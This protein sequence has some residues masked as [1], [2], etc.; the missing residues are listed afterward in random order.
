MGRNALPE[1]ISSLSKSEK[2]HVLLFLKR[3][4]SDSIL[5]DLYKAYSDG[6]KKVASLKEEI[7][8]FHFHNN[9]LY[10][11]ILLALRNVHQ[12]KNVEGR[13]RALITDGEIL[14]HRSLYEQA[15]TK[16]GAAKALSK[17]HEKF[18]LELECIELDRKIRHRMETLNSPK[19]LL[20][21]EW[22]RE[23]ELIESIKIRCGYRYFAYEIFGLSRQ[24]AVLRDQQKLQMYDSI[25]HPDWFSNEELANS[26]QAKI[27]LYNSLGILHRAK[28]DFDKLYEIRKKIIALIDRY[29][30]QVKEIPGVYLSSLNNMIIACFHLEKF[31]EGLRF[32]HLLKKHPVR[33]RDEKLRVFVNTSSLELGYYDYTKKYK[34]GIISAI[35][36][37]RQLIEVEQDIGVHN[38][39]ALWFNLATIYFKASELKKAS[40][41]LTNVINEKGEKFR[42][43]ILTFGRILQLFILLETGEH[44]QL[45]SLLKSSVRI[46][47]KQNRLFR[48]EDE[49][50]TWFGTVKENKITKADYLNLYRKLNGFIDDGAFKETDDIVG[51]LDWLKEKCSR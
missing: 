27:D 43:E 42:V 3:N 15:L 37:E 45:Q 21:V 16:A 50:L 40:R 48:F 8:N 41:C 36:V 30:E 28:G 23:Q 19:G 26:F 17:K 9:Y 39:L 14:L 24:E 6:E 22:D 2:K 32:I 38:R 51:I 11:Q 1:L 47:D 4:K 12:E 35:D 20:K 25:L 18:T 33:N 44:R 29:P 5:L 46:I 13:I 49:I 7:D 31:D 10:Q 34:E